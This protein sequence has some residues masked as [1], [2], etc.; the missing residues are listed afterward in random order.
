M[1]IFDH[2]FRDPTCASCH[3]SIDPFGYAFEN[4][5]PMGSWRNEYTM[6][7]ATKPSAKELM[8]IINQDKERAAKG[9]PPVPKPW[10]NKPIPVDSSAK[11]RNGSEYKDIIEFRK[12]MLTD[13]NREQFVR[14]FITKLL[15][16]ANGVEPD[17]YSEVGKILRKSAENDSR[18]IET[19]AAVVD[20]PLF[21]EE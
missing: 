12:L 8:A 3:K 15:T 14:C 9:L 1:G 11:F 7:I 16:Y 17:N 2:L 4:F 5:D 13:D 20:N 18:I 10:N 6:Q 21:R 19:I